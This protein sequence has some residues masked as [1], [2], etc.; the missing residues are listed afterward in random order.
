MTVVPGASLGCIK[1]D[2]GY[3]GRVLMNMVVNARDAMP[4]GGR[5]AITTENVELDSASAPADV[6]AGEY[7]VLSVTDTGTGMTDDVKAHLFEAFF[8]TK[9]KGKGTGLGLATCQ[10]IVQQSGGQITLKS[11]VGNGTTFTMYFPRVAAPVGAAASP[12]QA[13]P[14]VRGTE[15]LLIV[16]DEPSVRHLAREVLQT[17]LAER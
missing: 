6:P 9:P 1:A 11:E 2:A 16:E 10:T 14:L 4:N 13:A 5:L 3:L 17:F 7:V 15:T 12:V 8:S